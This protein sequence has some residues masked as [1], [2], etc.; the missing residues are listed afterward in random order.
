MID[1]DWILRLFYNQS[2]VEICR[3]LYQ[4]KVE[5]DN[6]SLNEQ[7]R[8]NDYH[9]SLTSILLYKQEYPVLFKYSVEE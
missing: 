5:K 1:F 3:S 4:R 2:S 8:L 9:H 7:Y 6:L